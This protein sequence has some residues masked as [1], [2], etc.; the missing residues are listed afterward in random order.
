MRYEL[1]RH[2]FAMIRAFYVVESA[3]DLARRVGHHSESKGSMMVLLR[4]M[5]PQI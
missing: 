2:R 4:Q 3:A 1:Y 5:S